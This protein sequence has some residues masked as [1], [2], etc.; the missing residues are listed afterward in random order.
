MASILARISFTVVALLF[1]LA[2]ARAT[3]Q[4]WIS[5][6][7]QGLSWG[8]L[9]STE[10]NSLVSNGAIQC[11]TTVANGTVLDLFADFSISFAS[12]TSGSTAPY[13]GI[14][15]YPLNEDGVTYGDGLFGSAATGP[16]VVQTCSIPVPPG[17]TGVIVGTGSCRGVVLPPGTF[18]LVIYNNAGATLASS[19]NVVKY[20]TYNY[21]SN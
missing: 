10:L 2:P 13:I 15:I 17:V 21:Q 3:T 5:G 7:G 12:I 11:T 6:S 20:R 4:R 14:S 16:P 18:I 19:G 1:A 9:C 8:T